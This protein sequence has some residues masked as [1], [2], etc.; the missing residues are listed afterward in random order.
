[1]LPGNKTGAYPL[2][3][4]KRQPTPNQPTKMNASKIQSLVNSAILI[5]ADSAS[6]LRPCDA[7]RV[8][9][10]AYENGIVPQVKQLLR[11]ENLTAF[12]ALFEYEGEL[13]E[14]KLALQA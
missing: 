5:A 13:I 10:F 12:R 9:D 3:I 8:Y 14:E 11:K 7:P 6:K 1:M 2:R 4:A